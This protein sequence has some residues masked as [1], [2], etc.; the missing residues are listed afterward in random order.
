MTLQ[1]A[2]CVLIRSF[3]GQDEVLSAGHGKGTGTCS[4]AGDAFVVLCKTN[5]HQRKY[6][7]HSL[8]HNAFK[9]F[10]GSLLHNMLANFL[11][12][13]YENYPLGIVSILK[14]AKRLLQ[15]EK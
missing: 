4:K 13:H 7:L 14:N 10:P 9:P 8:A 1:K 6:I 3:K 12:K 2:Q 15:G 11:K 5:E